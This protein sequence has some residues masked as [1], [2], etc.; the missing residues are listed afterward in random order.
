MAS[1]NATHK[2]IS[3]ISIDCSPGGTCHLLSWSSF[4][5]P[6]L[7]AAGQSLPPG[8]RPQTCSHAG[9][10]AQYTEQHISHGKARMPLLQELPCLQ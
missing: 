5:L 4:P 9:K 3:L 8:G 7:C 6:P 2:N 1:A 10:T